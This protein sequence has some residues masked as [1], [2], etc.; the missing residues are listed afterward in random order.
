M[1]HLRVIYPVTALQAKLPRYIVNCFLAAGYDTLEV[2]ADVDDDCLQ[3]IEQFISE[4]Y[5]NDP[6]YTPT[7]IPIH[8]PFKFPP[9]HRKRI[10]K[11]VGRMKEIVRSRKRQIRPSFQK[12]KRKKSITET[13]SSSTGSGSYNKAHKQNSTSNCQVAENTKRCEVETAKGT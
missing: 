1:T 12:P 8:T 4:Q 13:D 9:G 11:F 3:E 7:K 2:I 10:Q 5:P 6:K